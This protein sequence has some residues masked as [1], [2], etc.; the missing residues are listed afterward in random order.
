MVASPASTELLKDASDL[1]PR[2]FLTAFVEEGK[3]VSRCP[4]QEFSPK[5]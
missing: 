1:L 4:C 3:T 5:S 2:A